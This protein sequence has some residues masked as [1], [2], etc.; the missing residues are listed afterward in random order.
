MDLNIHIINGSELAVLQCIAFGANTYTW[1]W[2]GG[3][4][5]NKAVP[6]EGGT[7]LEIS[8]IRRE[9]AGDYRCVARNSA[10]TSTSQYARITVTGEILY[11][12]KK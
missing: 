12:Y 9:E 5:P 4:I 11:N 10:G 1:E 3:A 6:K 2:L 8:N 7:I